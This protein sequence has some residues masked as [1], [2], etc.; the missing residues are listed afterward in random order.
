MGD[1]FELK[2]SCWRVNQ[3]QILNARVCWTPQIL[4][5]KPLEGTPAEEKSSAMSS[6]GSVRAT[7]CPEP[8]R[9]LN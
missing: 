9:H 5:K 4:T 3:D 2:G 7:L 1:L 8:P 6:L